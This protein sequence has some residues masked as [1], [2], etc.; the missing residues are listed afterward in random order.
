MREMGW[1]HSSSFYE[2]ALTQ[3]LCLVLEWERWDGFI[4]VFWNG[5]SLLGVWLMIGTSSFRVLLEGKRWNRYITM[6]SPLDICS[7]E[8]HISFSQLLHLPSTV[9][10]TQLP[11]TRDVLMPGQGRA[12]L[13][14]SHVHLASRLS[15]CSGA[16]SPSAKVA[17]ARVGA[18][19]RRSSVPGHTTL[20]QAVARGWR[21]LARDGWRGEVQ[22]AVC[23][24]VHVIIVGQHMAG[25]EPSSNNDAGARTGY[26]WKWRRWRR[27]CCAMEA[28]LPARPTVG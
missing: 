20:G 13:H 24:P 25:V 12:C 18:E 10:A 4:L 6:S 16:R 5:W 17:P 23:V 15:V 7:N 1:I 22:V 8:T 28:R 26:P 27:S 21:R 19:A 11:M 14:Q 2:L 9:E 3:M